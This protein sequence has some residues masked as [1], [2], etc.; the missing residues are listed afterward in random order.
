[1]C[2][3]QTQNFCVCGSEW[4]GSVVVVGVVMERKRGEEGGKRMRS[5]RP[6]RQAEVGVEKGGEWGGLL[7]VP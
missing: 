7:C 3:L 2:V 4:V 6:L 5:S 1:M